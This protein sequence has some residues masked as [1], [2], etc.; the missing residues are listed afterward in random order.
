MKNINKLIFTTIL[1]VSGL[2]QGQK[3]IGKTTIDGSA[4]LDFGTENKGIILPWVTSTATT[5]G[6]VGGTF[7]YDISDKRVKMHNG[8]TWID[9]T[10]T[11]GS[12]DTSNQ[13]TLTEN[14]SVNVVIGTTPATAPGVLVLESNNMALILP[15][16]ANPV[17]NILSP[18]AGTMV[19]DTTTH[20]ICFFNGTVW[21]FWGN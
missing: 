11:T 8:T 14:T 13:D 1:L 21:S 7:I 5:T 20:K 10:T 18:S 6:A 9:L 2:V 17:A 4:L 16:N 12:V 15:R 19:Y 3:A